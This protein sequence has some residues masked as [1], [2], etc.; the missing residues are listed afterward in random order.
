MSLGVRRAEGRL[1]V[2]G[3]PLDVGRGCPGGLLEERAERATGVCDSV[4][5]GE[6]RTHAQQWGCAGRRIVTAGPPERGGQETEV[7]VFLI[8]SL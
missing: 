6:S 8:I 1:A 4:C 5:A 3:G 2:A 7:F